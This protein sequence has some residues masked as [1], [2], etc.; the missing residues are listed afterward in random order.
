MK[1]I[2]TF[3]SARKFFGLPDGAYLYTDTVWQQSF[4]QDSSV[5]RMSHLLK[6]VD[7][8]A[9]AGYEDFRVND[10]ALVGQDIKTMSNLTEALLAGIDYESAKKKRIE[11][12]NT[13]TKALG[14]TNQ[15][16]FN[17]GAGDV[18]MVYPY[19]TDDANIKKRLITEKIFVATYWPNVFEWCKPDE[20]E[21]KLADRVSYIR[22]DHR[23]SKS[24]MYRIN[25]IIM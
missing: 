11:N 13:L 24:D 10:D 9:K 12:Y 17:L 20:L 1:G 22:I 23:Y 5:N 18:P 16:H 21:Y 15:F 7:L 3:Y 6:R 2:D 19:L 8:G 4:E 14:A 25:E